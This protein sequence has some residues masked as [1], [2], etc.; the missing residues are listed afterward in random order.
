MLRLFECKRPDGSICLVVAADSDRAAILAAK[1]GPAGEWTVREVSEVRGESGDVYQVSVTRT[2]GEKYLVVTHMDD[3][4]QRFQFWTAEE[5]ADMTARLVNENSTAG[6]VSLTV[7]RIDLSGSK[8]Q[9]V[10]MDIEWVTDGH[11]RVV[12]VIGRRPHKDLNKRQVEFIVVGAGT[13]EAP[14]WVLQP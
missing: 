3:D 10:Q 14:K 1:G 13:A 11:G 12:R 2:D 7:Y 4:S 6:M 8:P 9:T 5:I